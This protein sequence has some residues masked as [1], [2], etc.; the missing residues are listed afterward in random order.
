MIGQKEI[1]SAL[2][3]RA[4]E[5]GWTAERLY[6]EIWDAAVDWAGGLVDYSPG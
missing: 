3:L 1:V 6:E 5:E 2:V 4:K